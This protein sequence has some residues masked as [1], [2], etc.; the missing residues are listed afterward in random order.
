MRP[1]LMIVGAVVVVVV[2]AHLAVFGFVRHMMRK[3]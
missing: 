1:D 3:R 2:I